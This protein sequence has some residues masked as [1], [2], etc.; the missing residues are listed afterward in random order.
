MPFITS[1]AKVLVSGAN[2][3]I[4]VWTVRTLLEQ[5]YFVRGT[6][7]SLER[8]AFLVDMFKSYG[9]KFELAVVEDIV[10]VNYK[11]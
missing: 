11:T 4:A 2:G 8:N 9:N 5:G 3:Y 7:R 1:G 10:E 6:V